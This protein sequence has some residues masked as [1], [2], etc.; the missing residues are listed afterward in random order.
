MPGV[1]EIR[2]RIRSIEET[3]KVTDAM[4][5]I[6]SVKMRRA[7]AEVENTEPYYSALSR[8]I[9]ELLLYLPDTENPYFHLSGRD[10]PNAL[11]LV[12]ADKGLAGS[13]NQSAIKLAENYLRAYPDTRLFI[14]G[15]YGRQYFGE[16]QIPF[17]EDFVYGSIQPSLRQAERI[18]LDLL[19]YYSERQVDEIHVVSTDYRGGRPS[20]CRRQCLLPLDQSSFYHANQGARD[21]FKEFYPDAESV[22]A[23]IIPSYLTGFL[24][25]ALVDSYCSEQAAR[26]TA[27]KTA[28]ENAE[29]VLGALRTQYNSLRQAAITREMTEITA[30][31]HALHQ[32]NEP[33][34][35]R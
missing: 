7:K 25:G 21:P 26:M 3:K 23:Q 10:L 12:T 8:Q 27:M 32:E 30:G 13:Y 29:G 15:A 24:Y 2:T 9:A 33:R 31:A 16:R 18:C 20:E 17:V 19:S 6:A 4:Y 34:G 11:L 35:G 28:G 1:A 5:R 14:I 22:L